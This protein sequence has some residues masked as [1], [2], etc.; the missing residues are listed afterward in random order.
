MDSSSSITSQADLQITSVYYKDQQST[1]VNVEPM[2]HL[3]GT[4]QWMVQ[5]TFSSTLVSPCHKNFSS[6]VQSIWYV[7]WSGQGVKHEGEKNHYTHLLFLFAII[8][9]CSQS[10]SRIQAN[11]YLQASTVQCTKEKKKESRNN[12][13]SECSENELTVN[14]AA[15]DRRGKLYEI[16]KYIMS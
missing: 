4:V 8:W 5:R 16:I 2:W 3:W 6:G 11:T 1:D 10:Q 7:C 13:Y 15:M 12:V 9:Q 14:W